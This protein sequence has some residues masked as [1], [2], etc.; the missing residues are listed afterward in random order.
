MYEDCIEKF[1]CNRYP[2]GCSKE[3]YRTSEGISVD[4]ETQ[5]IFGDNSTVTHPAFNSTCHE[6]E[7]VIPN[8]VVVEGA[9]GKDGL[10]GKDLE[11]QWVY[12]DTEIRLGVRVK[13]TEQWFYS[14]SLIGPQG[15]IGPEGPKGPQGP[16]GP[17]GD[18]GP[19]GPKGEIGPEGPKGNDGTVSFEK[20]TEE[21]KA[22]LVGPQGPQGDVGPEGPQ[23]PIGPQGPKGEI[24]PEGPKGDVGPAGNNGL[25]PYIGENNNWWVGETDTG[26]NAV[27]PKKF[28]FNAIIPVVGWTDTAPYTI[29]VPVVGM[30]ESDKNFPISPVYADDLYEAQS[31]AW[32]KVSYINAGSDK[33]IVT[34]KSELPTTAIPI[35]ITVVR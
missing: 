5:V 28:I 11:F 30:L 13:G 17:Q 10:N 19:Q 32:S 6:Q 1:N 21:Q 8:V 7:R 18:A 3:C 9:P 31:E 23:G 33:I 34:C 22:S 29:E 26:I 2:N 24:G 12:T 4:C 25:T 20:L 16:E 14:P 27:A 15:P 35:Q